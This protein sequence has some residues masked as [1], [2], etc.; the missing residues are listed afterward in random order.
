MINELLISE[1]PKC[2]YIII[3]QKQCRLLEGPFIAVGKSGLLHFVLSCV[4]KDLEGKLMNI[5]HAELFSAL[6]NFY[7]L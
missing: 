6:V 5:S 7:I 4:E 1:S 2:N 3:L